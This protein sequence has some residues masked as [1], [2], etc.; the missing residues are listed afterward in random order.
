LVPDYD[1]FR[2]SYGGFAF[3]LYDRRPDK[4]PYNLKPELVRALSR[5]YGAPVTPEQVF[6]AIL[7]L[8]SARSYTRRFAEDLED[9]F[10]HV[11]FPAS[12]DVF[13]EAACIGADIRVI[14]TFA[15]A[16]DPHYAQIARAETPPRG[17]LAPVEGLED[18]GFSL[19]ADGS[20]R[21]GNVPQEVWD[22]AVSGYRVLP[23]WIN[24]RAQ[25]AVEIDHNFIPD[26]RDVAQRIAELLFLFA[27][28]NRILDATLADSLPR[29]VLGVGAEEEPQ[30][31]EPD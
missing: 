27:E 19:C 26:L 4:G 6:D 11:P 25:E 24:A 10:P 14:E 9:V 1:F 5:R 13:R 30:D 16:P 20:G 29:A 28:A 17:P 7:C 15:R 12:P 22:F 21:I 2:G 18:G 23:R 31:E 3:P 8:L